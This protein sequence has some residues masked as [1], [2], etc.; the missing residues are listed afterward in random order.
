M[1]RKQSLLVVLLLLVLFIP[2]KAQNPPNCQNLVAGHRYAF[3]FSGFVD[4]GPPIGLT[5]NAGGG[6]ETFIAM[7]RSL[8]QSGSALVG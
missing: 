5:T 3:V 6:W 8:P 4:L 1:A 2:L 7:G